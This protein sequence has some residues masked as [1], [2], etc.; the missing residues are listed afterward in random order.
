MDFKLNEEQ[1]LLKESVRRF[2]R[3]RVTPLVA[4]YE[5]REE[6]PW[7]LLPELKQFGYLGGILPED[8][9]GFGM[10]YLDYGVLMEEAGYQWMA[11]RGTLNTMNVTATLLG[12]YGTE[13]Q[14]EKY[15][16]PLLEGKRKIFAAI[17]EPNHGSNVAGIETKAVECEGGYAISGSK[18]WITNGIWADFGI[19]VAKTQSA[20]GSKGLSI[21]IV[22]REQSK[23][24][25]ERVK[26][27]IV[28]ATGTSA[29]TFDETI[30][31]RENLLGEEGQGLRMILTGLNLGRLSVAM[32][33]IGAAQ[34]AFDLSKEY[35]RTRKQFGQPIGTYQLV[36]KH[37]VDM[38]VKVEASRM[39]GFKAAWAL[40][41]GQDARLE[42]SIAK[43]YATEAAHEVASMALQV[44]GGMGYS[45]DYPIERIFR[46]TRG[47]VI[48]EGTSEIQTLIIGREILGMSAFGTE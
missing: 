31:P 43:L 41:S 5:K 22:D 15:L 19:V 32:G 24:V 48:P 47:S 27:M 6:F 26:T 38:A 36:Q 37:I 14:K 17:T 9:G 7:E 28:R 8:Q 39:L 33:A 20:K 4:E 40:D 42:C 25:A 21:F 34:A 30:V 3:D 2:M 11:L 10:S 35:A 16:V 46:D 18:L 12:K 45:T 29:L 13:Q 23:Y 1:S 44:H